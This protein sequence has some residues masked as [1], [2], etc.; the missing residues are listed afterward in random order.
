MRTTCLLAGF[1]LTSM[2]FAANSSGADP[3]LMNLVMPDAASLAGINVAN[4]KNTPFGQYV[5][6]Q[7]TSAV[8]DQLQSFVSSTGFDPRQD[9]S[10]VLA[11]SASGPASSGLVLALGN[12]QVSQLTAAAAAKSPQM[13]VTSYGGATLISRYWHHWNGC[14]GHEDQFLRCLYGHERRNSGRHRVCEGGH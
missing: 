13:T 7:V 10:E 2:L 14:R 5:I 12:F 3:R 11:A 6:T 1:T 4:A 8:A 9:V